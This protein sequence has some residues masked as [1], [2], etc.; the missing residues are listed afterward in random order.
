MRYHQATLIAVAIAAASFAL[1][2]AASAPD[3]TTA[4]AEAAEPGRKLCREGRRLYN[5]GRIMPTR[6]CVRPAEPVEMAKV[7]RHPAK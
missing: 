2:A 7:A 5:P 4:T 6:H 1:P 3:G